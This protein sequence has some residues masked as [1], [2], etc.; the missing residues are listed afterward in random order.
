M[1]QSPSTDS[2]WEPRNRYLQ[3]W[4]ALNLLLHQDRSFSGRERNC[5]FLNT[6]GPTLANVSS[7]SGLDF[8]DDA[9]AVAVVDWDHDGDLDLWLANRTAPRARLM[10]NQGQGHGSYIAFTLVGNGTTTNRD[11]IGARVEL[12]VG[13]DDAQRQIKTLR[14]GEGFLTQSSKTMHFGLGDARR[15]DR[16]VV[17]WPGGRTETFREL[18]PNTRY[19]VHQDGRAEVVA[20]RP[21]VALPVDVGPAAPAAS[22]TARVVLTSPLPLPPMRYVD[23]QGQKVPL[24]A[25]GRR[26]LLV[27]LWASWCQ[28]CIQELGAW[29]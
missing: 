20:A 14:A 19:I 18:A 28:P 24:A 23:W 17:H 4:K 25:S 12:Y 11:A 21:P 22:D 29:T 27:N 7:V 16:L 15:V 8:A 13:D 2:P 26:P 6:R 3:G 10:L 9:R 1:S 5:V